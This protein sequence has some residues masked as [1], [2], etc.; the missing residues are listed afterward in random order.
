MK[1]RNAILALVVMGLSLG[2]VPPDLS[3]YQDYTESKFSEPVLLETF[4]RKLD[5]WKL[6]KGFKIVPGTGVYG[7]SALEFYRPDAKKNSISRKRIEIQPNIYYKI[8]MDY[9]TEQTE[10]PKY[11]I[12]EIFCVRF[13]RKN[14]QYISGSFSAKSQFNQTDWGKMGRVFL[15]PQETA[16][17]EIHLLMRTGRTGRIWFDN[18]QVEPISRRGS[19]IFPLTPKKLTFDQS[20]RIKVKA[21]PEGKLK[22]EKLQVAIEVNGKMQLLPLTDDWTAEADF[23]KLPQGKVA[24]K[25]FLLD[26]KEKAVIARY[27]GEFYSR[28]AQNQITIDEEGF[29]VENGKRFLP[30]GIYMG[31]ADVRHDP[32]V[33]KRVREAGFNTIEQ[34]GTE[35]FYVKKKSTFADNVKASLDA[36]HQAGLRYVYAIKCQIPTAGNGRDKLD[37]VNGRS[38]VTDY[39]VDLVKDHPAMLAWYCSDENP[40]TDMPHLIELRRRVSCRDG[41]HPTLA[42]TEKFED[43]PRFAQTAD[44]I[45]TDIYP[46][47]NLITQFGPEQNMKSCR[48]G[49]IKAAATGLPVWWVPQIFS[50]SSFRNVDSNRRY[51]T[52][53]EIRSMILQGTI[54]GVQGY[55]L[56]AYHPIFYLSEKKDPGKSAMQ[57]KNVVPSVKLLNELAPF[58]LSK[59]KAPEVTVKQ[60][61]GNL[62]EA[63][64]FRCGGKVKVVITALGPGPA[65]AEIIVNGETGLKSRY[66]RTMN[67]GSSKYVFKG[68]HISSDVLE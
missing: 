18:I 53:E 40:V 64:A 6:G 11:K 16:Y 5:G 65:E 48:E 55:L 28:P 15:P 19:T 67:M 7:T 66:G 22:K 14:G 62:I 13:Y 56:Y 31:N 63:R 30:I 50:W 23:G 54:R 20:G 9:R 12:M 47:N 45:M 36:V 21:V 10:D 34:I 27:A 57:W 1:K 29:L 41:L 51:P 68:L 2:A 58:I 42:L 3:K 4:D 8:S 61:S 46:V 52:A 37:H 44:I 26:Q 35:F 39:I 60:I 49:L 24:V 17:A 43:Y 25:L 32:D 38:A 59:E 33:L